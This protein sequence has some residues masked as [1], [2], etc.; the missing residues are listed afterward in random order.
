MSKKIDES[1][2]VQELV[3]RKNK[4]TIRQNISSLKDKEEQKAVRQVL[5]E[6]TN[7]IE[8]IYSLNILAREKAFECFFH[9]YNYLRSHDRLSRQSNG[10]TEE[11]KDFLQ[12][13]LED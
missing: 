8:L 2:V 12:G 5:R 9:I 3:D 6:L 7:T 10:F 13:V 11:E 1:A 4:E